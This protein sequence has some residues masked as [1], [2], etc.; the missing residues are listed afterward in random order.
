MS[1]EKL[2]AQISRERGDIES[3][4]V[5]KLGP[6]VGRCGVCGRPARTLSPYEVVDGTTRYKGECCRW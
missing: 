4:P 2:N 3:A 5:V 6:P 1:D